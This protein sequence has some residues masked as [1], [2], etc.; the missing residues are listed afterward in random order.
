MVVSDNTI[1][2]EGLGDFLK[3][4]GEKPVKVGEKVLKNVI[5]Y[6][7]TILEFGT[8][9][10]SAFASRR[11]K[12]TLSALPEVINC[13]QTGKRLYRRKFV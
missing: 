8:N 11:P 4:L 6:Q 7:G 1:A 10:G 13:Y 3:S 12:T 2:T 9:V 5:K